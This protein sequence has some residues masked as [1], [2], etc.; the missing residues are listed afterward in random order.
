MKT[1]PHC[2]AQISETSKFCSEC[3]YSFNGSAQPAKA[4][5]K[6]FLIKLI[7]NLLFLVFA[8]SL[9]GVFAESVIS[10]L[11][12]SI[13]L[14]CDSA[15]IHDS[16]ISFI[17]VLS[18]LLVIFAVFTVIAAVVTAALK[19]VAYK[20]GKPINSKTDWISFAC[21]AL[22]FL[23]GFITCVV[24]AS[25]QALFVGACPVW[26]IIMPIIFTCLLGAFKV[27][28]K[29]G[30]T[31]PETI[32]ARQEQSLSA[33]QNDNK[34]NNESTVEREEVVNKKA[35]RKKRKAI[36]PEVFLLLFA[37]VMFFLYGSSSIIYFSPNYVMHFSLFSYNF[38]NIE[39]GTKM[40]VNII[41]IAF[42]VYLAIVVVAA[43]VLLVKGCRRNFGNNHENAKGSKTLLI[44]LIMQIIYVLL[45][46]AM[47][48][49]VIMTIDLEIY[50]GCYFLVGVPLV[51]AIGTIIAMVKTKKKRNEEATENLE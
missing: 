40:I 50:I 11:S 48:L 4:Q 32:V 7:P 33:A 25:H 28:I 51:S 14:L 23:I 43:V 42:W 21:Y 36:L 1:C 13:Y 6:D 10:G 37:V 22:Y 18:I 20:N 3:G 38:A 34:S 47:M 31:A 9:F 24:I 27:Y 5:S 17:S 39:S 45:V 16:S 41:Q 29:Y 35:N 15:I 49:I 26:L 8:I 44:S 30:A 46:A 12:A 19:Y 2:G